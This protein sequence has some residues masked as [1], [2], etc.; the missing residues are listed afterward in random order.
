MS[1]GT[2]VGHACFGTM[3][4]PAFRRREHGPGSNTEPQNLSPRC[5]SRE[6]PKRKHREGLSTEGRRVSVGRREAQGRNDP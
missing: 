1:A 6:R 5:V 3:R 2:S 4:H